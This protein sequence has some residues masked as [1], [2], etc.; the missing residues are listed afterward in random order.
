MREDR[1]GGRIYIDLDLDPLK[2]LRI[3][4]P[5]TSFNTIFFSCKCKAGIIFENGAYLGQVLQNDGFTTTTRAATTNLKMI[6]AEVL[7]N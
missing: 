6:P 7:I 1:R 2:I 3:R 5:N 4:I